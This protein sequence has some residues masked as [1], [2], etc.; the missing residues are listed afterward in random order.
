M[1][2]SKPIASETLARRRVSSGFRVLGGASRLAQGVHIETAA[3]YPGRD[4][5]VL[6]TRTV[7]FGCTLALSGLIVL[8]SAVSAAGLRRVVNGKHVM[9]GAGQGYPSL[10]QASANNLIYHG[11]MVEVTP[12]VY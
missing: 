7:L 11:G 4:L 12:A 5:S 6:S 1:R 10:D 9:W 8:S 3:N 2:D